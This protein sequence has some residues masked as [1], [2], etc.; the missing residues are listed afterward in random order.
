MNIAT[1]KPK[2]KPHSKAVNNL[3]KDISNLLNLLHLSHEAIICID[4]AQTIVVFNDGAENTFGY[5]HNEIIGSPLSRLIPERFH[6]EHSSHV[7]KFISGNQR[8]KLMAQRSSI[9]GLHKN[10]NEFSAHASISQF[11][12]GGEKTMSVVLHNIDDQL[13]EK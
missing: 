6:N 3:Y 2:R 13:I 9:T 10:G 7:E 12:Y 1:N 4:M 11:S 8:A 5:K